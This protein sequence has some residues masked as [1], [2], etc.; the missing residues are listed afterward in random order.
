MFNGVVDRRT[1]VERA[2]DI[3]PGPGEI[4]GVA[5]RSRLGHAGR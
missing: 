4:P 3:L 2:I 5:T 1:T